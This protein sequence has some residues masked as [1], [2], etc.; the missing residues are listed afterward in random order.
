MEITHVNPHGAVDLR[1]AIAS[2]TLTAEERSKVQDVLARRKKITDLIAPHLGT[3]GLARIK[4]ARYRFG[5]NMTPETVADLVAAVVRE[6]SQPAIDRELNDSTAPHL[7]KIGDELAPIALAKIAD[8]RKSVAKS[9]REHKKLVASSPFAADT[10]D[11][12]EARMVK[13]EALFAEW[14]KTVREEHGAVQLLSDFDLLIHTIDGEQIA[15]EI[16]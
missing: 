2:L 3:N 14:E 13:T 11:I 12:V 8:I 7:D 5:D 10:S 16:D 1:P 6:K 4:A 15:D 9:V